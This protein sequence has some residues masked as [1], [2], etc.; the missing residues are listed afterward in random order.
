MRKIEENDWSYKYFSIIWELLASRRSKEFLLR[1]LFSYEKSLSWT[2]ILEASLDLYSNIHHQKASREAIPLDRQRKIPIK[3]GDFSKEFFTPVYLEDKFI[4]SYFLWNQ[5]I[6]Y[7]VRITT[8]ELPWFRW[9]PGDD[10][11]KIEKVTTY[12]TF[13][14]RNWTNSQNVGKEGPSDSL[15]PKP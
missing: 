15:I 5:I 2:S 1:N 3:S 9:L 10:S 12:A 6:F 14:L 13:F 11:H 4:I 8:C 7:S